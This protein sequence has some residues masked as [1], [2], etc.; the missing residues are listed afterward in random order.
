[1]GL[2]FHS[3]GMKEGARAD[4]SGGVEKGLTQECI[5]LVF[6]CSEGG[7]CG[8]LSPAGGSSSRLQGRCSAA[9]TDHMARV[10]TGTAPTGS[11]HR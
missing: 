3:L 4:A 1:M 10:I 5:L 9:G 7:Q 2:S 8:D 6:G 11:F